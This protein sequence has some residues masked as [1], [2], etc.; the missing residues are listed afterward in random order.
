[1]TQRK[2]AAS[3]AAIDPTVLARLNRGEEATATLSEALAV[4]FGVLLG[5]VAPELPAAD[6][7]T[8]A[9]AREQGITQR[10]TLVASL[11]RERLGDDALAAWQHHPSDTVRGWVA[12]GIGKHPALPLTA[13]L[14]A[15][16]PFA[17]DDHFGVRE[18]AWLAVRDHIA[19]E[20]QAAIAWLQAWT[21]SDSANLRRFAIE[22]TRPRGVW[23]KHI[24]E[25]KQTP[26]WGRPLLDA[27]MTDE[28]R[29][30]QDACGNW[31]N[32]AA[33]SNPAWVQAFCAAWRTKSDAAATRYIVKRGL[34]NLA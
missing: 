28:S 13:K 20:I 21:A 1:M 6:R 18:W 32:D 19:A 12:F 2:G 9:D 22:S 14:E 17:D 15:L 3:R 33:K 5:V 30:V 24:P 27:V 29:Y 34:R 31:L 26:D 11:L 10:M 8:V 23:A 7:K 25:L 4:D 16:R